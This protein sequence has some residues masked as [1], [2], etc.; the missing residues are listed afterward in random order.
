MVKG[1]THQLSDIWK[2]TSTIEKV[3]YIGVVVL[4]IYILNVASVKSV[5]NFQQI[6]EFINKH[7]ENI[8]DDFYVNVYDD[9]LFSEFKNEYEIGIIENTSSPTKQ[10]IILDIGSGTGHHVG[11]LTKKGY[12]CQGVDLS[13]SM[14]EKAKQNYPACNYIQGDATK[15]MTFQP[16]SFTHI[17]C[18]YFTLYTIKNKKNFFQNC[19]HWLMPSGYL[20]LHLVD[21]DKFDPILPVGDVLASINPQDYAKKR[22]TTTQ[23]AFKNH[24]YKSNFKLVDNK[25]FFIETFT[26][27][28]TGTV[29]KHTH[30][31]YM[32][33]QKH[34]LSLAQNA[35]FILIETNEMKKVGYNNQYIYTLQK[36]N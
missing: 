31:L 19:M 17:T 29:R 12:H 7:G 35:G 16:N 8:Y 27:R 33:S 34:I 32:E 2:K 5:E 26:N 28:K 1:I 14:V 30:E 4:F 6:T 21:R 20:I 3:F 13:K 10:S 25:G 9:I 18:L 11:E 36:P 23:A 24:F 15:T 22:I